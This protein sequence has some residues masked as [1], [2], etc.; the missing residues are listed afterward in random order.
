METVKLTC[1][2]VCQ[3]PN[4]RETMNESGKLI[5]QRSNQY[6]TFSHNGL[7]SVPYSFFTLDKENTAE[8]AKF[9]KSMYNVDSEN[10]LKIS[11]DDLQFLIKN[12]FQIERDENNAI[13]IHRGK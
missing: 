3:A 10:D 9:I 2:V 8:L 1:R 6:L 11:N 5:V 4:L 12:G 13:H 7:R